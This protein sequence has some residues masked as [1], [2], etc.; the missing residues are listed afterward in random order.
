MPFSEGFWRQ[1]GERNSIDYVSRLFHPQLN[2][3]I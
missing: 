3:I 2:E 1:G